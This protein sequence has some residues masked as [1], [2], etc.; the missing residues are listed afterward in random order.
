MQNY[1]IRNLYPRDLSSLGPNVATNQ[2]SQRSLSPQS[3]AERNN[4]VRSAS[5]RSWLDMKV[6]YSSRSSSEIN[7]ERLVEQKRHRRITQA[8]GISYDGLKQAPHRRGFGLW[9]SGFAASPPRAHARE[10]VRHAGSL[11]ALFCES[12]TILPQLLATI[13]HE[14]HTRFSRPKEC[15][16]DIGL[17]RL[18]PQS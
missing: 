9:R 10:E 4:D 14:Y 17:G 5:L 15:R 7:V 13:R 12:G 6:G 18:C 16:A 1:E 11:S 2:G 3:L 8:R